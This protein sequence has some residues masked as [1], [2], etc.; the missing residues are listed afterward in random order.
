MVV[1]LMVMAAAALVLVL[2]LPGLC[3]EALEL[4]LEAVLV[5]HGGAEGL[6]VELV[7]GRGDDDGVMVV[8]AEHVHAGL[9]LGLAHAAGAG[10][11]DGPG[12]FDLVAPEFTEVLHVHLRA[13][14][15]HN[16]GEGTGDEVRVPHVLHGA[17]D[18]GELADAGGLY[19]DAVRRKLGLDLFQRLCKISDEAAADAAG[20]HLGDLDSGVFQEPAVNGDLTELVFD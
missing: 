3:G 11:D 2:M 19:E 5:L 10:E 17:D 13:R 15:V 12:V 9:D 8:L 1:M 14:G 16:G 18:V 4:G 6:A 20:A 7:P